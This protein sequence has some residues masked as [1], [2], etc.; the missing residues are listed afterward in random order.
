MKTASTR[1]FLIFGL[2]LAV[3]VL[4]YL[5][6]RHPPDSAATVGIVGVVG[7]LVLAGGWILQ[8]IRGRGQKQ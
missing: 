7:A 1:L 8:R 2:S 5:P 4:L 6:S 3:W